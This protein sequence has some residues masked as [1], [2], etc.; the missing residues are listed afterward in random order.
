MN[1]CTTCAKT[2]DCFSGVCDLASIYPQGKTLTYLSKEV[3]LTDSTI[4]LSSSALGSLAPY[5]FVL[6]TGTEYTMG[7]PTLPNQVTQNGCSACS[8]CLARVT[9]NAYISTS[10]TCSTNVYS[11]PCKKCSNTCVS[12]CNPELIAYCGV[13]TEVEDGVTYPLLTNVIRGLDRDKC[14]RV[15]VASNFKHHKVNEIIIVNDADIMRNQYMCLMM[16]KIQLL[17]C[18][19]GQCIN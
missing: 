3:L 16:E 11:S 10:Q 14:G 13:T 4:R 17:L 18:K 2:N 8:E 9:T 5:G 12:I 6:F 19:T 7:N 1:I 15:P